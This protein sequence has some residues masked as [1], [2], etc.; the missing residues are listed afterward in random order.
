MRKQ[1]GV[2][3]IGWIFLLVPVAIVLYAGIRVGPVYYE[4]FKLISAIEATAKDLKVEEVLTPVAI[5]SS[6]QRR[7]DT[8]YV[9][10]IK[11]NELDVTRGEAG[12]V[13][14]VVYDEEVPMFWNL[15]LLLRFDKTVPIN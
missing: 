5:R 6:L 3:M 9:D 11:A 7:F 12:W 13:V 14:N 2:T 1:R 4:Y 15:L 8:Q 10:F